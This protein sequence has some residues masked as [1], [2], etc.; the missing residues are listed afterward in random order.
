[1]RMSASTIKFQII[2]PERIVYEDEVDAVILPTKQG[3]I[4]VL[5]E[6]IPLVSSLAQGELVIRKN[7]QEIPLVVL[8]GF[9][10]VNK[11]S[12]VTILADM[13]ERVEEIDEERA[14]AARARAEK[15]M[16]EEYKDDVKFSDARAALGRSLARL[17]VARKY[18]HRR[19]QTHIKP[20]DQN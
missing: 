14:K 8:G 9:V 1:M 2:T 12:Q 17:K 4:T 18:R 7:S 3:E 19:S 13:A 11:P 20:E 15:L 5:P 16:T 10:E 6:H